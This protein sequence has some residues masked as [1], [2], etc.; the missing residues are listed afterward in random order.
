VLAAYPGDVVERVVQLSN[1]K[2]EVHFKGVN[3][4]R[5]IFVNQVFKVVGA[6]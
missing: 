2:Y 3:W 5:H 6:N 4:P 1:G